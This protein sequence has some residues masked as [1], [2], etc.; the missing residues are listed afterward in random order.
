[1]I[2]QTT[3]RTL[4][5]LFSED[6]SLVTVVTHA[7]IINVTHTVSALYAIF[8]YVKRL[9]IFTQLKKVIGKGVWTITNTTE[10]RTFN[11]YG[12]GVG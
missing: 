3:N 9:K 12:I 7:L 1:M 4:Q 6:M 5:P 2:P 11:V 8:F 10:L